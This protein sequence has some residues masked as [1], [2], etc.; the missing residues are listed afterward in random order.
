MMLTVTSFIKH[1][2]LIPRVKV[3]K[4]EIENGG[5]ITISEFFSSGPS[6]VYQTL[7]RS[8]TTDA[9]RCQINLLWK[10]SLVFKNPRP[11]W[12]GTMQH[13]YR[14]SH[15]GRSSYMYLPLIDM[16]PTNISS[17]YSTLKFISTHASKYDIIPVDII[18]VRPTTVLES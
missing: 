3:S 10:A 11:D 2:T 17:I 7:H 16:D 15:P 1:K 6:F 14:G 4:S 8:S 13:V 18:P 12:F 9:D 5:R